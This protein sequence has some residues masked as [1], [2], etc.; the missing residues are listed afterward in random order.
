MCEK[1]ELMKKT[2][3]FGQPCVQ[4]GIQDI[5]QTKLVGPQMSCG[6]KKKKGLPTFS[7]SRR[8]TASSLC[9]QRFINKRL[10]LGFRH[11][12]NSG[13]ELLPECSRFFTAL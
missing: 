4:T 7:F 10:T 8:H 11:R 9:E 12:G 1:Q 5:S 3:G 2:N 13:E 6:Y